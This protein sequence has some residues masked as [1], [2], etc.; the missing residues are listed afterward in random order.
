MSAHV[1][2]NALGL[3]RVNLDYERLQN[4]P[5]DVTG[6]ATPR[7]VL[8]RALGWELHALMRYRLLLEQP[9]DSDSLPVGVASICHAFQQALRE[10]DAQA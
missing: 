1:Q 9:M 5:D 2:P 6:L 3:R 4:D 10:H 8:T 7:A